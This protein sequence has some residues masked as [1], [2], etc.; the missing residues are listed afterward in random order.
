[1][2]GFFTS[3]Q[4]DPAAKNDNGA[5]TASVQALLI[6]VQPA[7]LSL[8]SFE[9]AQFGACPDGKAERNHVHAIGNVVDR[10]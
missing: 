7:H 6:S 1:M 8:C 5:C 9:N 10:S 3:W 4:E 2:Q